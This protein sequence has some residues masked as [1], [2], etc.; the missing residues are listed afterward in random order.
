[1][2]AIFWWCYLILIGTL[3]FGWSKIAQIEN[4][5]WQSMTPMEKKAITNLITDKY[6][7]AYPWCSRAQF[8][9]VEGI[10]AEIFAKCMEE[11]I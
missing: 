4:K 2:R 8:R 1:M 5:S 11:C 6:F 7:E 3:I 10:D 9:I